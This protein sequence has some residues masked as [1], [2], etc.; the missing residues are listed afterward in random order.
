MASKAMKKT[1]FTLKH[2]LSCREDEH[3]ITNLSEG[4]I[5]ALIGEF[6]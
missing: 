3:K 2:L 4:K 6:R 5:S 1:V